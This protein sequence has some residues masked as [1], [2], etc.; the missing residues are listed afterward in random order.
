MQA[1]SQ[2]NYQATNA[3]NTTGTY[4]DLGTSGSA[5]TTKFT[6]GTLTYDE[7]TSSVQNIGF[8]FTYNG[9]SFTQF[10]LNTNGFIKLGSSAPANSYDVSLAAYLEANIIAPFNLD[11]EGG[12]SPEYRVSTSG[13]V[14]SRVCTIQFKNL[15]DYPPSPFTAG[16]NQYTSINFQIRLYESS[17]NI[18]FVY[19]TFTPTTTLSTFTP[20]TAGIRGSDATNAVNVTKASAT[21]WASATFLNGPY[22]GNR[23]N[24]RN[25]VLPT[26]GH[27]FRFAPSFAQDL[28]IARIETLGKLAKD[29]AGPQTIKALIS[30]VGTAAVATYTATLNVTGANTYTNVKTISTSTAIG[31]TS[32]VTFDPVTFANSGT[33]TVTVTL[34][35]DNNNSNNTSTLSQ[36]VGDV[37]SFA[38]NSPITGAVGY[39]TGAGLLLT[40]YKMVGTGFVTAVNVSIANAAAVTGNTVY[41]VVLNTAGAIIG[42]SPN[43]VVVAGDLG[44]V[45]TFIISTPPSIAN[46]SF[47]VG[48]AQT[49]NATTGY[50]PVNFQSE[51]IPTRDQAFWTAAITGGSIPS[52]NTTIGR[53]YTEALVSSTAVFPV[54]FASF[55]GKVNNEDAILNWS[56][57]TEV[58]N[59][60]FE[61]QKSPDG[62]D[63]ATI[64]FVAG[65]GNSTNTNNYQFTDRK[66]ATGN[67]YYR[68]KQLDKDGRFEYSSIIKL[69]KSARNNFEVIVINPSK[70][71]VKLQVNS[72]T[73]ERVSIN[74]FN[75]NGQLVATKNTEIGA[76]SNSLSIGQNL[77]KG[78]YIVTITKKGEISSYKVLVD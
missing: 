72:E 1:F 6:S 73:E 20:A 58:N 54:K 41:G 55:T 48:L 38:D 16:T 34:S 24:H 30:N 35:A 50:F 18:E 70:N 66:I 52:Q 13:A 3:V 53:F 11:L 25:G 8:A 46:D 17:N 37:F 39:N 77:S 33:N 47:Y 23:C 36:I 12:T 62:S 61:I 64:G 78:T 45:K 68:L 56:T 60:G 21:A 29:F 9:S 43:Y 26:P 71:N 44:N 5:I 49:A 57:S 27:L 59:N 28:T 65:A 15:R 74:L 31:G 10:V 76:G 19:G 63:F 40:K 51:G 4:T 32:L 42:Q 2:Y 7:D 67:H 22:T 69:N 75:M 14:G